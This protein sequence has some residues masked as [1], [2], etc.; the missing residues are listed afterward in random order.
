MK[1]EYIQLAFFNDDSLSPPADEKSQEY[2]EENKDIDFYDTGFCMDEILYTQKEKESV[3]GE[4]AR[5]LN[6]HEIYNGISK[7]KLK[8]WFANIAMSHF[9]EFC[10][11]VTGNDLIEIAK[12]FGIEVKA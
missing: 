9:G 11:N 2:E 5:G 7:Q 12:E 10:P 3:L 8:S 1:P 6:L 4:L